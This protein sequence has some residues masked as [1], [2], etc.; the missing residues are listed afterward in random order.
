MLHFTSHALWFS[1][2]FDW[3][4]YILTLTRLD[5]VCPVAWVYIEI[6]FSVDANS[7]LAF[8]IICV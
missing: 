8:A 7:L 1:S 4:V 3:Y 6:T 2:A 5:S